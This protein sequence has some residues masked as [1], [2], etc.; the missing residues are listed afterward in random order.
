[1][2]MMTL[3]GGTGRGSKKRRVKMGSFFA[4]VCLFAPIYICLLVFVDGNDKMWLVTGRR[5]KKRRMKLG[6]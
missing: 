5:G 4:F 2:M 1:M 6:V 3:G